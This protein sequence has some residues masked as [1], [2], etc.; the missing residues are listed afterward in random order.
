M[1]LLSLD[2][3]QSQQLI[4]HAVKDRP[5]T[6]AKHDDDADDGEHEDGYLISRPCLS[7]SVHPSIR[8]SLHSGTP[9]PNHQTLCKPFPRE[10]RRTDS[11]TSTP[12]GNPSPRSQLPTSR[13]YTALPLLSLL[14]SLLPH[15]PSN[16]PSTPI[17]HIPNIN[18]RPL[19][20]LPL[21]SPVP[22]AIH[23]SIPPSHTIPTDQGSELA[24]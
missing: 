23:P 10:H 1:W 22:S 3:S 15:P 8:P 12:R 2:Q 6:L 17:S 18:H 5:N 21:L 9:Y 24:S 4:P 13:P 14:S 11:A 20:P 19:S 7:P 16:H